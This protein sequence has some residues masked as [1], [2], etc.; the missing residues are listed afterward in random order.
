MSVDDNSYVVIIVISPLTHSV[1]TLFPIHYASNKMATQQEQHFVV[2][3]LLLSV[4]TPDTS[5]NAG[6][7]DS[8]PIGGGGGSGYS[9]VNRPLSSR[10]SSASQKTPDLMSG[11]MKGNKVPGL[12]SIPKM[13]S[14][15]QEAIRGGGVI[16]GAGSEPIMGG[17]MTQ[18]MTQSM[19]EK[20]SQ[21]FSLESNPLGD[22]VKGITM[23]RDPD[24]GRD[25]FA[26]ISSRGYQVEDHDVTTE[27]GYI[28]GLQRIVNPYK[29]GTSMKPVILF[30]GI[31]ESGADFINNSPGGNYDEDLSVVG[32]N[33][34]FE[35]A[36]RDY[37]VWLGNARG[38]LYSRKH[39]KL[40]PETDMDY[41]NFSWD[42]FAGKDLPAIISFIQKQTGRTKIGYIGH[43]Q[44]TTI[45]FG[46][47]SDKPEYGDIISPFIAL[48]P[49]TTVAN[50]SSPVCV[51]G[52]RPGFVAAIKQKKGKVFPDEA[53]R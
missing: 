21:P 24:I 30:H 10:L 43:S 46:L 36:K 13:P 15:G 14:A 26:L 50:C 19:Q 45:M 2:V 1:T 49:V 6:L 47:L 39:P 12:Q 11:F 27:D 32:N 16:P 29:K 20:M 37:D 35:L 28:V 23:Q 7:F 3:F 5:V 9:R 34:G 51:S 17:A 44:G 33:L 25:V 4:L 18:S 31:M 42:E 41:W 48:A 52:R 53:L 8:L 22:A 38:N 40:N